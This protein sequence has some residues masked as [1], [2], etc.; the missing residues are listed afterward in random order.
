MSTDKTRIAL[1]SENKNL[2]Q[3]FEALMKTYNSDR[4]E[5][6]EILCTVEPHKIQ[7]FL[8]SILFVDQHSAEKLPDTVWGSI[9]PGGIAI[10]PDHEQI[11]DSLKNTINF[12][13]KIPFT[14]P[15]TEDTGRGLMLITDDIDIPLQTKDVNIIENLNGLQQLAQA[16]AVSQEDFWEAA[17]EYAD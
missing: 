3:F 1:V 14:K 2:H 17:S 10:Y 9:T 5:D 11:E 8:P 12:F 7:E 16:T 13:R 6:F 15:T 4:S